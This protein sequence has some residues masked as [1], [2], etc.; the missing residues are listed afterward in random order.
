KHDGVLDK[1]SG[2]L[3]ELNSA[4]DNLNT[5]YPDDPKMP[6]LETI[7]TNDD[8]KEEANFTNLESLIHVSPTLTTR[9]HK[10]HPLKQ[11]ELL[12]FKLQKVWVL[13]D[14]P[15][16]KKAIV[17]I[18]AIRLFLA[19]AS[20]IRFMVYQMDMK[21]AFLY[22]RIEEEVYMCQPLRFEDLDHPDKFYKVVKTLYG[23]YQAPRAWYETLAKYLL[24]NGFHRGKIDQTLFIKRQKRDILLVQVYIDDIIF[25]STKKELYVKSSNTLVDIE[26]T[27]VKDADGDDVDVH[28]NRSMIGSL[29]YLTASRPDN[30]DYAGAC[31]DIKSTTGGYQFL[32]SRLISWQCKK[33]TVIATSTTKAE[34]VDAAS[35]SR[36][37]LWIQNQMLDYGVKSLEDGVKFLMFLRFVQVLLDSQVEGLVKHKEIYV[38]PSHTKKIFTNMKRRGKDFSDEHVTTTSNDLLL[39]GEDRLKLTELMKLCT[40]LQLRVIAL[41]TTKANQALEIRSLKRRVKKLEKKGSKKTH[42][43]KRLYKIGSSTRVKSSKDVGLVDQ[44]DASK[45]GRMIVD[46]N[47]DEGV[48]LEVNTAEV[49]TTADE[50]VAT[51]GVEVSIAAITSQ[52]SMDEITLAKALID[53]KTSKPKAKGIAK[54]KGKAKMI[55]PEKLL[56]R[57]DQ[58]MIYEEVA[59]NLEAHMQAKLEEEERLARQKEEKS[60]IALIESWDNT[61]AMMDANYELRVKKIRSKPP[62]KTQKRNQTCTYLKN[63]ANYKHIKGNE[64]PAEGSE[65]VAEG[66]SKR[67]ADKLEQKDAKRQRIEE[68]NESA[69]L[70]RCLEIIL[71]NDDDV[72]IE[73]TPLS[74]KSPTIVDYKIYKKGGKAFSKSSEQMVD[75]EVEMAYDLLRL[76]RRQ[77][78]EG[79]VPE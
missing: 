32:G 46:L 62:T 25:G 49:V 29:M 64:K 74:S 28:L 8:S 34:Y 40:Q 19:Y 44:E 47:A 37:V 53:I 78:N 4:F 21:S 26:K 35:C 30:I 13:V 15:K 52:I 6:G 9:T 23:L 17:R 27:L 63:M 36:Q 72:T 11:E 55:E 14:L 71:D 65:K 39:S 43:L 24:G 38:T 45:Q 58:I 76:I 77:I 31:L 73:A 59:K 57:K 16:G 12:Q 68:E 33:Q 5:E 10:N 2:A 48:T 7:A 51:A 1:E 20:L 50:V 56:K 54:E 66:S 42:K 3:N 70:N 67:G 69:E 18:K 61:Q 75:Y 22:E 60:N 41:E 79:H